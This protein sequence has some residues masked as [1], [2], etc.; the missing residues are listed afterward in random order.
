MLSA[1]ASIPPTT[2]VAFTAAFGEAT[3]S[4]SASRSP[5]PADSAS[6][7]SGT[8][9][10]ADTRLGSSNTGRILCDACTREMHFA[11]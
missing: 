7:G 3:V 4:P 2:P 10:A 8:R 6:P 1:P 5:R 9:P 11:R